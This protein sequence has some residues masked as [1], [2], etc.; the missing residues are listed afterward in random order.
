[1]LAQFVAN[2]I[3]W[4]DKFYIL[5]FVKFHFAERQIP[6]SLFKLSKSYTCTILISTVVIISRALI[7]GVLN[8]LGYEITR[9]AGEPDV[10]ASV[11][12]RSYVRSSRLIVRTDENES[13]T[14]RSH[15]LSVRPMAPS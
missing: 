6:T 10:D 5:S 12:P 1:M 15:L 7:R 3:A 2:F 13:R 9:G 14:F 8:F 11:L 4:S